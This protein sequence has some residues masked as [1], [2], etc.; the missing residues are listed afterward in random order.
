MNSKYILNKR[1][2]PVCE[3][4]LI[5]WAKWFEKADRTVGRKYVGP[6][7]VSTVFLA[8]DYNVKGLGPPILWETT[9]FGG[10]LDQHQERCSGSREQAEAMHVRTVDMVKKA[11]REVTMTRTEAIQEACGTIETAARHIVQLRRMQRR[12]TDEQRLELWADLQRGYCC[13]R[14]SRHLPCYCASCFD[15]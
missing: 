12:M 7:F 11:R 1:G 15:E 6:V 5:K 2:N 9:V 4:G 10:K 3:P 8:L 13:L 14:G